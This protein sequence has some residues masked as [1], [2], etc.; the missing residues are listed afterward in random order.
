M[1]EHICI[2]VT[3]LTACRML[4]AMASIFGST[5]VARKSVEKAIGDIG[6]IIASRK[7]ISKSTCSFTLLAIESF[8]SFYAA[9]E[10]QFSA[11]R[12]VLFA[13]DDGEYLRE[14]RRAE[15]FLIIG[16]QSRNVLKSICMKRQSQPPAAAAEQVSFLANRRHSIKWQGN[17][18]PAIIASCRISQNQIDDGGEITDCQ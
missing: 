9:Y 16:Q 11:A 3:R 8:A 6:R 12:A 2:I 13:C 17:L 18:A 5:D 14:Y 15:C 7:I 10:T 4:F 1:R